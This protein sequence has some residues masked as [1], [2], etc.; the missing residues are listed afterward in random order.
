MKLAVEKKVV[1]RPIF[2]ENLG[3]AYSAALAFVKPKRMAVEDTEEYS[4]A[5]EALW[6]AC[7]NWDEDL[8]NK[9]STYAHVCMKNAILNGLKGR[10]NALESLDENTIDDKNLND[11]S[12]VEDLIKFLFEEIPKE[13]EADKRNKQVVFQHYVQN[14]SWEELGKQF[15]VTKNR[16]F[17]YG[18]CGIL[19][20]RNKNAM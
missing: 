20:L 8:D 11:E 9:F 10:K 7:Q 19:L 6:K 13:S 1:K 17:Q 18:K 2:E 12:D 14:V 15:G 3:L 16:A 5:M 4:Y